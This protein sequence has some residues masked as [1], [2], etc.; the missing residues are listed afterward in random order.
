MTVVIARRTVLPG[1]QHRGCCRC[2]S[3]VLPEKRKQEPNGVHE[4]IRVKSPALKSM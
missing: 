2:G 3:Q 1:K 4:G